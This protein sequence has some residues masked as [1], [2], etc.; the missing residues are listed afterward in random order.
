MHVSWTGLSAE[1]HSWAPMVNFWL[2]LPLPGLL[3]S[4]VLFFCVTGGILVWLSFGPMTGAAVQRLKGVVP[5]VMGAIAVILAILIGFLASDIWERERGAAAA[6]RAEANQLVALD[7]LAATFGLPRD[8][9][10]AA[11]RTYAAT[12]VQKEWPSMEREQASPD[13]EN[14]LDQLFKAVDALDLNTANRG[15]LDRLMTSTAL[16]VRTARNTRLSLAQNHSDD[17][18]WLSVLALAVMAQVSVAMVHLERPRPQIAAL[19]VLTISIIIVTG[20]LAAHELPFSAP[21]PISPAPLAHVLA[22]VPAG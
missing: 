14:A 9:L 17:A 10:D 4:L 22:L 11:I 6:V 15:D 12:V 5:P 20:T 1:V 18:K 16:E 13:A 7:R 2:T 19:A 3:A 8:S 21:L